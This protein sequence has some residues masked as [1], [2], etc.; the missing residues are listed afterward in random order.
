[1]AIRNPWISHA[2]A[3]MVSRN[4]LHLILYVFFSIV[5]WCILIIFKCLVKL[6]GFHRVCLRKLLVCE[7]YWFVKIVGYLGFSLRIV[8]TNFS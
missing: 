3:D 1:M 4:T 5:S 6:L 7:N 2:L 8:F